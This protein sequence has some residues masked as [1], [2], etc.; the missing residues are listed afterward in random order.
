M[1][2]HPSDT[3]HYHH[4]HQQCEMMNALATPSNNADLDRVQLESQQN[5]R[6]PVKAMCVLGI[7]Q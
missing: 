4:Y 1:L 5:S 2:E 6:D 7:G 3:G